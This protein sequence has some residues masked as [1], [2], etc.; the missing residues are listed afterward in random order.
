MTRPLESRFAET[1]P[2]GVVFQEALDFHRQKVSLPSAGWRDL[3]GRA[4]DRAFVVAGAMK[5]GL[6]ADLRT[7]IDRGL[8]GKTTLTE[9]RTRFDAIVE[10]H[11][12]TGWTGEDTE[13]GRAW[14]T[15]VIYETNLKTAYA[16]GRYAQMTDPDVVKVYRF[17]RYRH[18]YYRRPAEPRPE[19]VSWDGL[20]LI[21]SDPWWETHY[22]PNDWECSCGVE[23][24]SARE[25]KAE[26]REPDAAPPVTTRPVRDPRTGETL[27]VPDGVGLGWDHAPGRDW[28]R[29]VVPRE[30]LNPLRPS[31]GPGRPPPELPLA[32]VA[33]PFTAARLPAGENDETY[34]RAF[35]AHFGA[36]IGRPAIV[37]DRAGHALAVSDALF[38]DASGAIKADKRGRGRDMARLAEALADPDEIWAD[39]GVGPGGATRLV[40]RYLR[41]APDGAGFVVFEW[42]ASGWSGVTAFPPER[43]PGRLDPDY[44]DRQRTGALLYRRAP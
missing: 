8:A 12:W 30:L 25:L 26:G 37:R 29:G 24:M 39:W 28:S 7:E 22:P 6:L 41:L 43:R 15:R 18:G 31:I 34:A 14:R 36:D 13:A 33:R 1:E 9:F 4:H 19:H 27:Q 44:L 16:A 5:E 35:L 20:T 23:T 40:R 32:E 17:W 3:T 2:F 10:K 11:G 21:W 42:S 38:R